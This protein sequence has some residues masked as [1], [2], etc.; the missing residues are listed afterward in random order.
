MTTLATVAA[1]LALYLLAAGYTFVRCVQFLERE[2]QARHDE[3]METDADTAGDALV[4]F[5]ACLLW[6][7]ILLAMLT[8]ALARHAHR[9]ASS[10][11][12]G[13]NGKHA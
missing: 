6:P 10:E 4:A 1:S 12:G 13:D 8:A 3:G 11:K 5:W 9:C 7:V 2:G